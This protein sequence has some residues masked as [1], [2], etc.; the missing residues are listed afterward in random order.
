VR[1]YPSP[2]EYR[3]SLGIRP[4]SPTWETF[5]HAVYGIPLTSDELTLFKQMSGG[6]SERPGVGWTETFANTGRG[7][8]K[9][10]THKS[11]ILYECLHG[12][13]EV[14]GEPRQRLP[15]DIILPLRGQ[16]Q[17]FV[18]MAQGEARLATNRRYVVSES[19][20]GIEFSNGTLVRVTTCDLVAVT[21]DT[22]IGGFFNEWSLWDDENSARSAIQVEANWRPSMRRM[23]GAP[24]KR[25]FKAGSSYIKDG[26]AWNCFRDHFGNDDSDILV[27]HGSTELFNP[28]IDRDWLAHERKRL[29]EVQYSMHFESEWQDATQTGYFPATAIEQCTRHGQSLIPVLPGRP[30]VI[31]IDAAFSENGDKIGFGVASSETGCTTIH[32]CGAWTVDRSPRELARRILVELCE[33]LRTRSIVIDQ[34]SAA[35]FKQIC[36]EEGLFVTV[37]NWVGGEGDHSKAG[38]YRWFKTALIGR[39]L[40]LPDVVELN[41]DLSACQST[42]LPGGGERI[43]VARSRRGHG[44]CLSAVVMACTEVSRSDFWVPSATEYLDAATALGE[45]DFSIR[46]PR[47][48]YQPGV[49]SFERGVFRL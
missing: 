1:I 22:A 33:P 5:V 7:S 2:V 12:G 47:T 26:E 10:D 44:D 25:L 42:L 46:E 19:A 38:K 40:A 39:E 37:I 3:K 13:H 6:R 21:G 27:V 32:R 30:L 31:A 14:A 36:E 11:L 17:G 24:V 28:N 18:R 20:D 23:V 43:G 15:D 29:G 41:R 9:D 45:T 8:G 4:F 49:S 16:A 48:A 34:F 35:A